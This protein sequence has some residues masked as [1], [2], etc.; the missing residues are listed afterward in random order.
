MAYQG[1]TIVVTGGAQGIGREIAWAY[2]KMGG[3]IIIADINRELG[4]KLQGEMEEAHIKAS[5]LYTDVAK[6]SDVKYMVAETLR[7][8]NKIDILINNAA[9]SYYSEDPLEMSLEKWNRIIGVNLTG[10]Y[11]CS[12]HCSRAMKLQGGG[13]IINMAS[14]RAFMSEAHTE[15]YSASKGGILSLTHA[16]AI[17]LG[18]YGIRVNA[19]SPGWIENQHYEQLRPIDHEQHPVGR[20]G[21]PG[22]V[23]KLCLYLSSDEAAFITGQNFTVDGGMTKKMIY[24][25]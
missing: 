12:K 17:S 16:L 25:P 1:K 19:I 22:D 2:G 23:A 18:K 14:T 4:N 9:I 10:T 21:R 3:S 6:E 13:N 20:V 11:L 8:Y 5:F 7:L 24:E 15:A